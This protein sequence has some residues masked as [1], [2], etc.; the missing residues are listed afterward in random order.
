MRRFL[1]SLVANAIALWLTTLIVAG[2]KI[3]PLGD[4]GTFATVLTYLIVALVFGIVNGLIGTIIRVVAFP[5]YI[6][7]LGIISLFVNALLLW[8]VA[9]VT[10]WFG[11]GLTLEGFWWTV[12]GAL[13]LAI[14]N[15]IIGAI[16]RPLAGKRNR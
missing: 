2:V 7:T 9:V 3:D 13:V 5:L 4:G 11:F 16:L 15:A 1:V 10:G 14:L 6:L 12:L 8:L